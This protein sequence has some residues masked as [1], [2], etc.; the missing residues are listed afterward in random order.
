[1]NLHGEPKQTWSDGFTAFVKFMQIKCTANRGHVH[2]VSLIQAFAA[3]PT[4]D[5]KVGFNSRCKWSQYGLKGF[6]V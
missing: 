6:P 1:M 2:A 3:R 5:I 4:R